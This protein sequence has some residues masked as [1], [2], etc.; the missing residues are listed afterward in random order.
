[1]LNQRLEVRQKLSLKLLLKQ[2]LELL[3]YQT[4]ELEKIIQEEALINPLVKGVFKKIPKSFE[5]RETVSYQIPYTP[6]ELEELEQNIRLEFE[7]REQKLALELLKY[8]DERGFLSKSVKEVSLEL[9]CSPEELE[10]IRQKVIRLEPLGICSKDIWE[11]L[12]IQIEEFYSEEREVLKKA[13]EELKEGKKVKPEIKEKLSRLRPFPLS[14]SLERVYTLAKVDAVIE[15]ENGEFFI[16]LYEDFIDIDLN[17]EYWEL[18]KKS[19]GLQREIKEA[20]ERYENIKRVLDI[21]RRNLRKVLEKIVER[22]RNFLLGRGGLRPLTLREVSREVGIH[23]STLSRIVNSKYVKTPVGT[24][25]LRT[26][27]V[28]ES[29]EGLTQNDLMK[30]IKEIVESEDKRK[31]YSDQEIANILKRK[32]FNVARR[33]VAKYREILGIPSSRERKV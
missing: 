4:Q 2:D 21:R 14:N 10:E 32:G 27:F 22:Q 33:T 5:V 30:L 18:Y 19:K 3:T 28:R 8:L 20:F 15:E 11:F 1:M 16:Y 17:E 26:F 6:S 7:G 25:S 23:E 24:Y 31:P 9:C 29:T 12:E 13:L